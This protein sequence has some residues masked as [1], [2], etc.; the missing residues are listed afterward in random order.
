MKTSA[1]SDGT[2]R[3]LRLQ[4]LKQEYDSAFRNL[5]AKAR[6][7]QKVQ[8]DASFGETA[9]REAWREVAEATSEY[10][11]SRNRLMEFLLPPGT[12]L[13]KP[14]IEQAAYFLWENAGR[15]S[16]TAEEDWYRAQQ[17]VAGKVAQV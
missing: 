2:R 15:P 1:L 16:G 4:I 5:A 9:V 6:R 13:R 11:S 8:D 7:L 10:Q 14:H 12:R 17:L 3:S